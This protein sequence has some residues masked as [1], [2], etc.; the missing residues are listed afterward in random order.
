[1]IYLTRLSGTIKNPILKQAWKNI[2]G[3]SRTQKMPGYSWS[4]SP[5]KCQFGKIL[6]KSPNNVCHICYARKGNYTFKNVKYA[7]SRRFERWEEN[8]ELWV[9][10]MIQL[11]QEC[12]CPF[13]RYFDSG[14]LQSY[15]ML[16]DIIEIAKAT[17]EMNYWLP[18]K[19]YLIIEAITGMTIPPNLNIRVSAPIINQILSKEK[20]KTLGWENCEITTSSVLAREKIIL[21][22][23][24][25][26][27]VYN[28][29]D[30]ETEKCRKCWDRNVK[31]VIYM[32]H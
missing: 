24:V 23:D 28:H 9:K 26:I 3:L 21:S 11:M 16:M 13:F 29:T 8:N 27:A 18:T 14:D 1:V 5:D 17:P 15:Q 32:K 22:D 7:H 2:G 20:I 25:C 6:K 10:S 31:N 19:E 4:L 30:C 12:D